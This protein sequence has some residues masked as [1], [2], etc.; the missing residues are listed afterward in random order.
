MKRF[1]AVLLK[2]AVDYPA[3]SRLIKQKNCFDKVVVGNKFR[4]YEGMSNS[5]VLTM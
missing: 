3:Q 2:I 1:L 4:V 5:S